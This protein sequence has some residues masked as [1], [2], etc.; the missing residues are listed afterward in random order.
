[1]RPVLLY[2]AMMVLLAACQE[3]WPQYAFLWQTK[4]ELVLMLAAGIG[5][6][7]GPAAGVG[8]GFFAGWLPAALAGAGVGSYL[9]TRMLAGYVAGSL[10]GRLF[11]DRLRVAALVCAGAAVLADVGRLILAPPL[12]IVQWLLSLFA[13]VL[14][15]LALGPVIYVPLR[16]IAR[17][18]PLRAEE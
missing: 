4:P 6:S 16:A 9:V 8:A 1:M 5:L 10:R 12:D 11:A 18:W 2:A 14:Y 17:Q 7:R 13:N 15:S 3:A